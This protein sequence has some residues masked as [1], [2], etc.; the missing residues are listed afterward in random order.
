MDERHKNYNKEI[1]EK[2][3]LDANKGIAT[4]AI[5]RIANET[6]EAFKAAQEKV[7]EAQKK[8]EEAQENVEEATVQPEGEVGEANEEIKQA[9]TK[10]LEE[11]EKTLKEAEKTL[12]KAEKTLEEAEEAKKTA[13]QAK[14]E[15]YKEDQVTLEA[16]IEEKKAN[17]L[18]KKE[19]G[20]QAVSV[21]KPVAS[22]AHEPRSA[23][24][25]LAVAGLERNKPIR[26]FEMTLF[27]FMKRKQKR[28]RNAV[29]FNH[30]TPFLYIFIY[31]P[32]RTIMSTSD[33]ISLSSSLS[34]D[35]NLDWNPLKCSCF[36]DGI[37]SL[38]S[39]YFSSRML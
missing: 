6:E 5:I 17:N 24:T 9:Q 25:R 20:G 1:L 29:F 33:F 11:A 26:I 14:T 3:S 31:I 2:R 30:K 38:F 16:T 23:K 8:V 36:E 10:A 39:L 37:L 12:E 21:V 32:L 27:L 15:L 28:V 22:N 13:R 35:S 34:S 18:K 7:K 4:F 19:F